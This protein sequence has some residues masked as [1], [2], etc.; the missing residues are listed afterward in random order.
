MLIMKWGGHGADKSQTQFTGDF[1]ADPNRYDLRISEVAA[2]WFDY[3]LHGKEDA[4]DAYSAVHYYTIG[5][6]DAPDAPGNVWRTADTWPPFETTETP[7]FFGPDGTLRGE[8]PTAAG[9]ASYSFDPNDPFPTLGGPLLLMPFGPYDQ[10][11]VTEGRDD[12]SAFVSEPL[13]Q[14]LEITGRVRVRLF[15]STD[16]P[17]TDFTAKLL[18]IYPDGRQI[19]MLDGIQRVKFRNGF[20]TAAP[21]L[22]DPE[23]VVEVTVDLWSTSWVVNTGHRLAVHVSSSN[24]PRFEVNPNTGEDFPGDTLRAARQTIHFGPEHPSALLLPIREE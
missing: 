20:E 6:A 17:D 4:L 21:L 3:H 8:P 15:I 14:P 9:T 10:R 5:D 7:I 11:A 16:A 24:F 19:N 22:D 12:Y 18:D 13:E 2:A 1:A 23:E